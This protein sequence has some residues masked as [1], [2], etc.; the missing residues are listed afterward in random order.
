MDK[1]AVTLV[2]AFLSLDG[3]I[4]MENSDTDARYVVSFSHGEMKVNDT[5][6]CLF[7]F[8]TGSLAGRPSIR[9]QIAVDTV[10]VKYKGSSN[11]SWPAHRFLQYLKKSG[12]ISSL[13]ALIFQMTYAWLSIETTMLSVLN[14]TV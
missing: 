11:I 10:R 6:N 7:G 5:I 1:K 9:L 4:K 12:F 13:M 14:S 2:A 8:R 3:V